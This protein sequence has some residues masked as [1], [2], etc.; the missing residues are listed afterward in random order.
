MIV[1]IVP[2]GKRGIRQNRMKFIERVMDGI[3][4]SF[5]KAHTEVSCNLIPEKTLNLPK[6]AYNKEVGKYFTR[7]FFDLGMEMKNKAEKVLAKEI[8]RILVVTDVDIYD[9]PYI[10]L[11][12]QANSSI[13]VVSIFRLKRRATNTKLLERTI[14]ES[15]HELGHTFGL[16]HCKNRDC[17]MNFSSIEYDIDDK[18]QFFCKS[19]SEVLATDGRES[20]D[21]WD[22][23]DV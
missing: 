8:K 21:A 11:Y 15:V 18:K 10:E 20:W 23:V 14:K 16:K 6:L 12:G 2:S 1:G 4:E 9:P 17:V 19:C 3:E 7:P 13:A 5:K 22:W